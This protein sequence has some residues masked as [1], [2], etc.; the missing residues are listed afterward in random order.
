MNATSVVLSLIALM[1]VVLLVIEYRR[2]KRIDGQERIK[3][4]IRRGWKR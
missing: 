1:V 2:S 4:E 3:A